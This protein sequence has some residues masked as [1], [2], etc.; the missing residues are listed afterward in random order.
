MKNYELNIRDANLKAHV[1]L[2]EE[3]TTRKNG[4]F[5]FTV[6][7]NNGNIVDSNITE[8]VNIKEKYGIIEAILI[9][10]VTIQLPDT[11][12]TGKRGEANTVRD[13]NNDSPD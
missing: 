12:N 7:V 6:R 13:N 8:Y 5:T 10:E 9:E 2:E 3:L 4:L 11:P 1:E